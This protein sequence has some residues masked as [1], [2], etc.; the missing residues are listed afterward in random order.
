MI[1]MILYHSYWTRSEDPL[2]DWIITLI[3]KFCKFKKYLIK[4][5]AST[6]KIFGQQ[7]F[8]G[9]DFTAN[10]RSGLLDNRFI[11][12]CFGLI[13]SLR[14]FCGGTTGNFF[15][16]LGNLTDFGCE[17]GAD[18]FCVLFQAPPDFSVPSVFHKLQR[19]IV[20]YFALIKSRRT[21][22]RLTP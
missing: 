4:I 15:A 6:H 12:S 20:I 7:K 2:I 13:G 17:V 3:I 21:I 11:D 1:S 16:L 9:V 19:I 22:R 14:R 5:S 10:S 8:F 18:L